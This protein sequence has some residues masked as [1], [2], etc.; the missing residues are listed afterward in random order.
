VIMYNQHVLFLTVSE[1]EAFIVYS[2]KGN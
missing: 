1:F 2:N